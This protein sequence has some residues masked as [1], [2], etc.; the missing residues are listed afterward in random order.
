MRS[1]ILL[2]SFV[3]LTARGVEV[4]SINNKESCRIVIFVNTISE[5][6]LFINNIE[7]STE[8]SLAVLM[9]EF[10]IRTL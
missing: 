3:L 10:C 7:R 2:F 4:P 6:N 8:L 9:E 5:S 1:I